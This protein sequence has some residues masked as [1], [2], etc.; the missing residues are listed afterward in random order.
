MITPDMI[1]TTVFHLSTLIGLVIIANIKAPYNKLT[2]CKIIFPKGTTKNIKE[3][4]KI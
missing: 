2:K 4:K 1:L 3:L